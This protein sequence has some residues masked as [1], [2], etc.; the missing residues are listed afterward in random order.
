[1]MIKSKGQKRFNWCI[2]AMLLLPQTI[3]LIQKPQLPA[4]RFFLIC[5]WLSV[6]LRKE[7]KGKKFPLMIPFI[8]YCI[9]FYLIGYN[10]EALQLFS[11]FW[12]PTSAII[13]SYLI[14]LLAYYGTDRITVNTKPIIYVLYLVTLYGIFTLVVRTNPYLDLVAASQHVASLQSYCFGD[15]IRITSTW[16]HPITYGFICSLFFY[17]FLSYYKEKKV[18]I[19]L[20]L[21]A[22]NI[23]IC[24]SRTD[25]AA[26]I[27]MGAMYI[28]MRFKA[29]KSIMV[30]SM[31]LI[32]ISI[33]YFTVPFV[34]DKIDQLINTANGT[35]QTGGSST[36]MRQDQLDASLYIFAQAP[37]CGHGPDYVQEQMIPNQ[38]IYTM[39]GLDFYGFESYGYIILI[40]RGIVGCI[41]EVLMMTSILIYAL[42][43]RRK[44]KE[45]SA[46]IISILVGFFFFSF[47]TGTMGTFMMT[48]LFIGMAMSK[49]RIKK[50]CLEKKKICTC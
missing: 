33:T 5:F 45:E 38:D 40:E 22:I 35:D 16:N 18:K 17:A 41:M 32:I 2:C 24:G 29:S 25:L 47:S 7:Y 3:I 26:F 13:E 4:H 49:I 1:M 39:Q 14:L 37:I 50:V 46:T 23:L 27:L 11:K 9:G 21:L 12:K 19:L 8:I 15:R 10:A 34:Q 36:E 31:T 48:M 28:P 42:Q 30:G 44:Y 20:V 6:L 43:H